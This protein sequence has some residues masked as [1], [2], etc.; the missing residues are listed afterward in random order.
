MVSYNILDYNSHWHSHSACTESNLTMRCLLPKWQVGCVYGT[1]KAGHRTEQNGMRSHPVIQKHTQ[2]SK[3]K[4]LLC[5]V[6]SGHTGYQQGNQAQIKELQSTLFHYFLPLL[7]GGKCRSLCTYMLL[8]TNLAR[9][10][11]A[12]G[13]CSTAIFRVGNDF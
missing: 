11:C 6:F 1:D 7:F 3:D 10:L 13:K 12:P 2:F 5:L 8:E 4:M 9:A